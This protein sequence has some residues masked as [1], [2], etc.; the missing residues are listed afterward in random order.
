MKELE[1]IEIAHKAFHTKGSRPLLVTCN[2]FQDWVCKYDRTALNLF[3]EV[4]ASKFAATWGI[5]TP[6]IAFI[7]VKKEHVPPDRFPKIPTHLFDK[8]CF[9]SLYLNN[10]KEIDETIIP[11]FYDAATRR[12]LHQKEDFLKIALFDLWLANEDRHHN[13]YNLLLH[14]S[15]EKY[16]FFYAIDH[17]QIFNSTFLDY[18]IAELTEDESLIK[19][20]IAKVL[21]K[22][23]KEL[24]RT[25]DNIIENF[26]LCSDKCRNSLDEILDLVPPSWE[27]NTNEIRER[28]DNQ[29]FSKEWLKNCEQ[30]FRELIKIFIEN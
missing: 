6:E 20:E 22:D 11:M 29:V 3:N 15:P 12:H 19:T 5:N 17:V 4:L 23:R 1:T 30:Q 28:I 18:G 13:N 27:I 26:Y 16:T 2:D 14:T 8:V 7:N 9:G 24:I 25:V 21:F 10:S